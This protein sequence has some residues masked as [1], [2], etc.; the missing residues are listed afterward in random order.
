MEKIAPLNVKIVLKQDVIFKVI[1]MNLNVI[2]LLM[3]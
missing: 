2:I 1:A 3:V